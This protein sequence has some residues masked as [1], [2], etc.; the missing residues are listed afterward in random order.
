MSKQMHLNLWL[1]PQYDSSQHTD[2]NSLIPM[3]L[4]GLYF[5]VEKSYK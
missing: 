4:G 3:V 1:Y 5:N 2:K